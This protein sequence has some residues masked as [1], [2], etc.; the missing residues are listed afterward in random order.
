[1]KHQAKGIGVKLKYY[2]VKYGRKFTDSA[3]ININ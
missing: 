1:M 3:K 2:I